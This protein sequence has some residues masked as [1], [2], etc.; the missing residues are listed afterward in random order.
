MGSFGGV[1][2]ESNTM[3]LGRTGQTTSTFIA[4]IATGLSGSPVVVSSTGQLGSVGS[5]ARYKHNIQTMGARSRA[6]FQLRPV[7]VRYKQDP[8]GVRQYGLIAEEV[9]KVYPE[10][11]TRRS[12]GTVE[13]V[14]YH[15]LIPMV[16]N[17][18]QRQQRELGE[19]KAQNTRLQAA[20][21]EQTAALAV[22]LVRLEGTHSQ[23]AKGRGPPWAPNQW[24]CAPELARSSAVSAC[25]QV[26][27]H[28]ERDRRVRG[29]VSNS[30]VTSL[31]AAGNNGRTAR[32]PQRR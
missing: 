29:A 5:S 25:N 21:R 32:L 8:R 20:L 22:R 16:L 10:L 26:R 17:E 2:T 24:S 1:A 19:L 31:M 27:H 9:A 15:E 28:R 4:G 12:D 23:A 11:V 13:S 6:L 18:L 14:Q 3:R 7:S 30:A